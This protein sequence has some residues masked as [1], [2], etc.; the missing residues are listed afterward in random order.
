MPTEVIVAAMSLI[1]T[2]GG[3]VVSS[4]LTN[5]RLEQLENVVREHNNFAKRMPVVE[6][7]IENL[8]D[9]VDRIEGVV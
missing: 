6:N 5:Y 7:K 3:I 1:G 8:V 2:F 4:R 9:R